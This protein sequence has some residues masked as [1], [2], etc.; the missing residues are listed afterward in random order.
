[1]TFSTGGVPRAPRCDVSEASFPPGNAL[2]TCPLGPDETGCRMKEY[3][4]LREVATA[5]MGP[6]NHKLL[7]NQINEMAREGWVVSSFS[8]THSTSVT[9]PVM[10]SSAWFCA[11]L[12]RDAKAPRTA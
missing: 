8:V 5:K 6:N 7:E 12:E 1:M 2:A 3:R 11:L 10:T 9:G 4:I